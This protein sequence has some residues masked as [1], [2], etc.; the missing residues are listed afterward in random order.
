V[1]TIRS[2]RR[3]D[4]SKRTCASSFEAMPGDSR[5]PASASHRVGTSRQSWARRS[6]TSIARCRATTCSSVVRPTRS[7]SDSSRSAP[8]GASTGPS[9]TTPRCTSRRA[10]DTVP[11]ATSTTGSFA[12]SDRP[13]D[14]FP[15]VTQSSSR[16]AT[17]S[18][19]PGRYVTRH[20]AFGATLLLNLDT[21]PDAMREYKGWR[22]VADRL[23]ESLNAT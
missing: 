13:C 2:S 15:R 18:R 6:T 10:L 12:S 17:T 8:S 23:R 19:R 22:G 11:M 21:A 3:H 16:S 14:D 5:L 4:W 9:S 1:T 20:A 7:S